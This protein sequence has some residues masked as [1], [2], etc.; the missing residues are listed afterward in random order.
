[1]HLPMC[2]K[3]TSSRPW[4]LM[5]QVRSS[6]RSDQ[7]ASLYRSRFDSRPLASLDSIPHPSYSTI[8]PLTATGSQQAG[9]LPQLNMTSR[10]RCR[11]IIARYIPLTSLSVA[12]KLVHWPNSYP[13]SPPFRSR[14]KT[15]LTGLNSS[16]SPLV[17]LVP[18]FSSV[19]LPLLYKTDGPG[20]PLLS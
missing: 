19:S 15:Q 1:M 12:L 20:L 7:P 16:P 14:T 17:S 3:N 10:S 6:K 11:L 18:S 8:L 5:M 2:A 4:T 9:I 13:N